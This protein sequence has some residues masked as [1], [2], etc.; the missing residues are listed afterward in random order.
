MSELFDEVDEEVRRDQL[1]KLWE[2]YSVVIIAGAI[3]IE[4]NC[5]PQQH[6]CSLHILVF[7]RGNVSQCAVVRLRAALA[8]VASTF[9]S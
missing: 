8:E 9:C 2:K 7:L 6:Y 1:K 4:R 3:L 5:Q